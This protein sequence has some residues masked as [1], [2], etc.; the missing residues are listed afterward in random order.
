MNS[1]TDDDDFERARRIHTVPPRVLY[2]NR[3][4]TDSFWTC[5][6]A[7]FFVAYIACGFYIVDHGQPRYVTNESGQRLISEFYLED[8]TECCAGDNAFGPVCDHLLLDGTRRLQAGNSTFDGDEGIFDAL[9]VPNSVAIL[10]ATYTGSQ[11]IKKL[12]Y[13]DYY[14]INIILDN[15]RAGQQAKKKLAFSNGGINVKFYLL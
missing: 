13:K 15:D 3:S 1:D 7:L 5:L 4:C 2:K 6:F 11:V 8:A 14:Q 12:M 9:L 10:G